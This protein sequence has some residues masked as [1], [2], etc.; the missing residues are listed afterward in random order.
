[1]I[2]KQQVE[3]NISNPS[4]EAITS[5]LFPSAHFA[6]TGRLVPVSKG[7]PVRWTRVTKALGTRL[8]WLRDQSY[9]MSPQKR[10][11]DKTWGT[12]WPRPR[13]RP[14]RILWPTLWPIGGLSF[15]NINTTLVRVER[16]EYADINFYHW[17]RGILKSH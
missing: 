10:G 1:M 11:V 2:L 12:P 8:F 9:S 15:K 5:I 3:E 17:N 13:C 14:W 7:C 4:E 16:V 6:E